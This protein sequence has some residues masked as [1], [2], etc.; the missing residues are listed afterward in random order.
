LKIIHKYYPNLNNHQIEKFN[1]LLPIYSEL[2]R[3]INLISR[4]D[5]KNFYTH[6]VLHS[7]SI[8]KFKKFM[9]GTRVL[10][11]GTGGGFPGIPLAIFFP[12]VNFYLID[13]IGKKINSV[14]KVIKKINLKNVV[15]KRVR[16]EEFNEI[17]DFVIVRAVS[18]IT[19]FLPWIRNNFSCSNLKSSEGGLICLKGGDLSDEISGFS[20]ID[21]VHLREYYDQDFFETKKLI[22]I[23]VKS[24]I[25]ESQ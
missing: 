12:N 9:P 15:A 8:A 18:K 7:L 4:K 5:M 25:N 20:C 24:F 22:Y 23:P 19:T 21:L 10:D 11:L 2:N 14:K 13:G 6:H 1:Q 17:V 3:D 16:A